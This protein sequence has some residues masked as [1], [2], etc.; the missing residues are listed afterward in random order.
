[1]DYP[2][3]MDDN[4]DI[5]RLAVK[6]LWGA[7]EWPAHYPARQYLRDIIQAARADERR[8]YGIFLNDEP[9]RG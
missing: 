1:M 6:L 2:D 7:K 8:K 3:T 9:P 5:E 4:P